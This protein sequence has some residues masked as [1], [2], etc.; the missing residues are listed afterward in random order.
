M[1]Y[2]IRIEELQDIEKF[3]YFNYELRNKI[4]EI[5]VNSGSSPRDFRIKIYD[6][7]INIMYGHN[8]TRNYSTSYYE[9]NDFARHNNGKTCTRYIPK[10]SKSYDKLIKL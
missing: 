5:F 7:V 1:E 8:N 9:T 4:K 2:Y 3:K 6:D 10:L